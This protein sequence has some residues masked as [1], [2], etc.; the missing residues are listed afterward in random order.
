MLTFFFEICENV[1]P[2]LFEIFNFAIFGSFSI[3]LVIFH[4]ALFSKS[5]STNFCHLLYKKNEIN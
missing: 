4:Q 1:W 5:L 3:I 2:V